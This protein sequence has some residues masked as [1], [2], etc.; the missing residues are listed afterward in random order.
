MNAARV[1]G[2][3]ASVATA[4]EARSALRWGVDI[5][6]LK[7]PAA[8]ALGALPLASVTEIVDLVGGEK[9]VSAT[10]GDL[11]AMP[12]NHLA[13]IIEAMAETGVDYVKVGL[14]PWQDVGA[15]VDALTRAADYGVAVI[16]V[17]FAD[18]PRDDAMLDRLSGRDIAGVM[19]DT[20][21]KDGRSLRDHLS[22]G[23]LRGFIERARGN[24]LLTGLAGSLRE[25]DIAPLLRLQ[26]DYLGFRGALCKAGQRID[27]LDAAAYR[28]VR[29]AFAAGHAGN[30][31]ADLGQE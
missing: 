26:P 2:M 27:R 16:A 9:P 8:G 5:I 14:F 17:L 11:P 21:G 6:D 30:V 24:G 19:L 1:P 25:S 3:L 22:D 31:S 15:Y 12:G 28:R 18:Q 13:A 23:Q 10:V 29:A 20:A 4:D 7:N